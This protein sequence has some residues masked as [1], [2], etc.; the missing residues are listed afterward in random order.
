VYKFIYSLTHLQRRKAS[1]RCRH[2]RH[3]RHGALR[4]RQVFAFIGHSSEKAGWTRGR[5]G[6]FQWP[7][8]SAVSCTVKPVRFNGRIKRSFVS[9]ADVAAWSDWAALYG[10]A[11]LRAVNSRKSQSSP[12]GTMYNRLRPPTAVTPTAAEHTVE[13]A[14]RLRSLRR[15]LHASAAT[16]TSPSIYE[17]KTRRVV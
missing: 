1:G 2:T 17:I 3:L 15:T 13:P 5:D 7:G 8:V 4:L 10:H 9:A 14:A 6:R 11:A 16:I 12:S